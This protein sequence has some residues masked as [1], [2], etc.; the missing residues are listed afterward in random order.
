[1]ASLEDKDESFQLEFA[2]SL[3][4]KYFQKNK[5]LDLNNFLKKF[6]DGS[7]EENNEAK[8]I[9]VVGNVCNENF[10]II[11]FVRFLNF[12]FYFAAV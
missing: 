10:L 5:L 2:S 12:K 7:S 11:F 3:L 8:P 6:T 9:N 1:L 4:N